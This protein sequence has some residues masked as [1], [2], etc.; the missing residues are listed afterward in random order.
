M[1]LWSDEVA[2]ALERAEVDRGGG[3]GVAEDRGG[4]R[5]GRLEV[6]E[7]QEGIRRGLDPDEVGP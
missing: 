1:P 7:G 2:A 4:M 6:G 5:G 3:G